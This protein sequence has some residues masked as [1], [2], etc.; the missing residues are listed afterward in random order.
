MTPIIQEI[1]VLYSTAAKRL[2]VYYRKTKGLPENASEEE[3]I[4]GC[5][6]YMIRYCQWASTTAIPFAFDTELKPTCNSRRLITTTTIIQY[7]GKH[8]LDDI[9]RP[10]PN[11]KDFHDLRADEYPKWWTTLRESFRKNHLRFQYNLQ[12]DF[13]FGVEECRPLYR[14]NGATIENESSIIDFLSACDLKCIMNSLIKKANVSNGYLQQRA[15]LAVTDSANARGG[16][17]RYQSYNDWQFHLHLQLTNIFWTE[18]KNRS[19]YAMPMIHD[20]KDWRF[21]FYHS[22]A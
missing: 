17:V 19:H 20:R 18:M 13:V 21:D 10:H 1:L 15:W 9:R 4:D 14:D 5:E 8:L 11:T 22:M 6:L 3:F 16:E 7:I 2:A 12:D